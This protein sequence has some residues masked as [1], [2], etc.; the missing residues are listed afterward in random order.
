MVAIAVVSAALIIV[1]SVFNGFEDLVKGLYAD[2]Y[3]DVVIL[4]SKGK[5]LQV[6]QNQF[7]A[8]KKI[9]GIAFYSTVVEEKAVLK[10][11]DAQSIIVL[12]GV[13]D[14][15]T[16]VSNIANHIVRGK[17]ILGNV[18]APQM[19]LGAGVENALAADVETA[20]NGLTV[21]MPNKANAV[22]LQSADA[23]NS[24]TVVATATFLVQQEFDNK[25]CFTN[26]DFARYMLNIDASMCSYIELKLSDKAN[27]KS[28]SKSIKE[29]LGKNILVQTRYEQNKS[30]YAVMQAE[31][32][33]I[34][35]V[36]SLILLIAA[37]NI[38]GSL[39]MLVLEKQKDIQILKAMG[40]NNNLI[41]NIFLT[42]GILLAFVGGI[43]GSAIA[44]FICWI[45]LKFKLIKLG[46][47][48]FLIDYYPV[49]MMWQDYVLSFT[50]IAIISFVAAYLPSKKAS[51]QPIQLKS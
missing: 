29:V 8:L 20:I 4:P 38:I 31:K 50:T 7:S 44:T 32:W 49:K 48:S 3:A 5:Q 42:E 17:F 18:E 30:L 9:N 2:F 19:V 45:Q 33:I 23:F 16:Q 46:G 34:Y 6:T 37:F 11:G 39:T 26:I 10:N 13:E 24:S 22:N 47:V 40:A 21:Y 14:N 15:Y 51:L 43:T 41:R 25:Y 1:L 28:I 35:G 36:L 12:K 27:I